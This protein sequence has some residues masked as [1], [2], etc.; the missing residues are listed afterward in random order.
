MHCLVRVSRRN[1]FP[2][3]LVIFF[4]LTFHIFKLLGDS[5]AY[6]SV[7]YTEGAIKYLLI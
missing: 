2:S 3:Y 7:I 4:Y 5:A 1:N 6:I